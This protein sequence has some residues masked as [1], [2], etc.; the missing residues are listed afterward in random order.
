[1]N[2][3]VIVKLAE[4]KWQFQQSVQRSNGNINTTNPYESTVES[5]IPPRSETPEKIWR[6]RFVVSMWVCGLVGI[7]C[8]PVYPISPE[9]WAS[10]EGFVPIGI[11]FA[12]L[13]SFCCS[14]ASVTTAI[15]LFR[16]PRWMDKIGAVICIMYVGWWPGF[17]ALYWWFYFAVQ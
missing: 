4:E 3:S 6:I 10:K 14:I 9:Y 11:H 13:G 15:G 1:M 16:L 12:W 2:R 5:D 7:Q 17:A 8:I